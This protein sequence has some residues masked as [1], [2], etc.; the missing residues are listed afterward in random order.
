MG[1]QMGLQMPIAALLLS[2]D[3]GIFLDLNTKRL[4]VL[5]SSQVSCTNT[6]EIILLDFT[7]ASWS[8]HG[9]NNEGFGTVKSKR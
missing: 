6:L 4:F 3:K 2:H 8:C 9:A 1:F 5:F 7:H